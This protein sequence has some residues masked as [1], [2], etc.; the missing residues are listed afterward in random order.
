MSS[1]LSEGSGRPGFVVV[2]MLCGLALLG[3]VVAGGYWL[4]DRKNRSDVAIAMTGGNPSAGPDQMRRFGCAGCHTISGVRGA[5]GKVG[6]SLDDL[7]SRVFIAGGLPN[8]PDNLVKWIV[9]PQSF[10]PHS[11]MPAT[12]ISEAQARDI[13]AFLYSR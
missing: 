12:G 5:D 9:T 4:S 2:A 7:R 13:A 11:A 8:T 6:P 3:A 10:A 1:A